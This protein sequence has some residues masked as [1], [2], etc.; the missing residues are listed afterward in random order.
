MTGIMCTTVGTGLTGL[1]DFVSQTISAITV[2]GGASAQYQVKSDGFDYAT[3]NPNAGT[4][5]KQWINITALAP[6]YEVYATLSSG[7]LSS[8]TT[9]SWLAT[10]TNPVWV[11][12]I[13]GPTSGINT[14][15]L[16]MQVRLIGSTTVLDTWQITLTAE[17]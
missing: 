9:G 16:A 12:S 1:V 15:V 11:V 2:S 7:S 14:G 8:G 3:A 5:S 17:K 13:A 6:N 10:T 4:T